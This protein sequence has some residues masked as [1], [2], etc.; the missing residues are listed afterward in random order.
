MTSRPLIA[1]GVAA[2]ALTVVA[3]SAFAAQP[4]DRRG[5]RVE[6]P[7]TRA[8]FV[9]RRTERLRAQDANGDG[10]VTREEMQAGRAAHRSER[11]EARFSRLDANGDGLIS[12][13]EF[14][15]AAEARPERAERP[16]RRGV[17]GSGPRGMDGERAR[18]MARHGAER[19]PE[20]RADR[21]AERGPIVIAEVEAR[22]AEQFARMDANGD[23]VIS[24]EER[25]AARHGAREHRRERAGQRRGMRGASPAA[26]TSE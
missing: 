5:A 21:L 13:D 19:G 26:P 11:A 2:L 10:Q 14:A 7:V 16:G 4:Q 23:G 22:A 25:Q 15:A 18:P 9:E 12:R 6:G 20:R 3:S 17:R 8:E 24:V 1:G